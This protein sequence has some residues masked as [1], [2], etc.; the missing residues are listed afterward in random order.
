MNN[1]LKTTMVGFVCVLFAA[2]GAGARNDVA[3]TTTP[4]TIMFCTQV[5]FG[6]DFTS[7]NA[8]FGNHDP[9]TGQCSRGGDLYIRYGTGQLRNLTNEAGYGIGPGNEIA[10][11]EPSVD[12]SGTKALF[13]M[14]VGGTTRDDYTPVYWQIYEVTGIGQGQTV[15]IRKIAQPTNTNNV[16]PLYGTDG[17][18]LFTS[19]RPR[20]GDRF[21]YPQLDE[22]ESQ[23][24]VTG[25]WSMNPD[26]T[27]LKLLDHA[28]SGDF[29]PIIASDGRVIFTRWD[30][31]QRD[32]QND[33][34]NNDYGAFNFASESSAQNMGVSTET[35]PELR[36]IP[37]NQFDHGHTINQFFPW[38][39]NE[40]GT[41]LETLNH[42]GRHELLSYFDSSN[43]TLPE[44]IAP[45]S[46]RTATNILH[47]KEDPL[48]PGYFYG[49]RAPEFETHAA[50]QIIGIDAPE[51]K[52][53]DQMQVDYVTDPNTA[54]PLNDG[55]TPPPNYPGHFRNPTPLTDGTLLVVRTGS[56]YA[57]DTTTGPL[58]TRYD[59]HLTRMTLGSGFA[60][61]GAKLLAS[62]ITK[63]VSYWDNQLYRQ[64]SYS[65]ALWELDPVEVRA[66]TVPARHQNPLPDIEQQILLTELGNQAAIDRLRGWLTSHRLALITSR[67]VTRRADRQQPFNLRVPGGVQTALPGSTPA[68]VLY[69]QFYQGDLV[70]GYSV[71]GPGRR[72]IARL[73]HGAP[74]PAVA[75]APPSSTKVGTDGSLAAFVPA[76]RALTWQ[77]TAPDGTPVIRERYWVTFAAGEIRSCSNCHGVNSTDTVLNQPAPT[78]PPAA[79]RDL[80][81]WWRDN[82]ANGTVGDTIGVVAASTSTFFLKNSNAGGPADLA[83]GFG[84]GNSG[85]VPLAGDWDG[86]GLDAPGFYAPSTGTFFLKNTNS[87]GAADI[88]FSFG[89]SGSGITPVTGDW[90]GDG[91]DTIG[92]YVASTGTFFLRNFNAPGNA[93]LAFAYGPAGATPLAG[94]WDNDG[95][96]SVGIYTASSGAFFLKNANSPGA[97]DI[98]FSFG[99][100]AVTWRV[101]AGD[102]NH[103][104]VDTP[105]LYNPSTGTFFLRNSNSAG[106]ADTAFSYGPTSG[107]APVVGNWN[108]A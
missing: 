81:R 29:T 85:W 34:G 13:S 39:M 40:D 58:T 63:N 61:V 106:A 10:V 57:D 26:G 30:H 96:D 62:P 73:M 6:Y 91:I 18:I 22:Y 3:A 79:F 8:V 74:R 37:Q 90:D 14:V 44:F 80:V 7:V 105:G 1:R 49:T 88:V 70:R 36:V 9:Y 67:D 94:D 47:L 83:F 42:V 11:R 84:P 86:D 103:D 21:T 41:A 43:D 19:D 2:V 64:L 87:P 5:P 31:L 72:P 4:P 25:I 65:G 50:G 45:Q 28:V 99:P 27:D 24:T 53:P 108:G 52:N 69:T 54:N 92:I 95:R 20:S 68:D 59:F 12:W 46:R 100:A 76:Q 93:D 38:Q 82:S 89:P 23:A 98:V 33:E 51:S 107:V 35:F 97:A 56:P 55:Q 71:I 101:L 77:L 60:T 78:N 32:Q 15:Q 48:R 16:S 104:G 75:G 66:R 17:R 102:W